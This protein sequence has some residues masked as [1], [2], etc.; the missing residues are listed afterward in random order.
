MSSAEASSSSEDKEEREVQL[1][2]AQ[3]KKGDELM[4]KAMKKLKKLALFEDK[5]EAA[6]ELLDDAAI[7]YKMVEKCKRCQ[8]LASWHRFFF[9]FF[10]FFPTA[11][12]VQGRKLVHAIRNSQKLLAPIWKPWQKL[13]NCIKMLAV[14]INVFL[15]TFWFEISTV[16]LCSCRSLYLFGC[17]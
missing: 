6:V 5:Y 10:V 3:E 2:S 11:S 14:H 12:Y 15:L 13:S 7:Q 4:E 16:L 8:F 9:A 1:I 17:L